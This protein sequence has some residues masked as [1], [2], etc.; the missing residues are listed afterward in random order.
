MLDGPV[1]T[2]LSGR[3]RW[4][5]PMRLSQVE[6]QYLVSRGIV[7]TVHAPNLAHDNPPIN[8]PIFN[9]VIQ[10]RKDEQVRRI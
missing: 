6:V 1:G 8:A 9:Q 5:L 4:N 7:Q 10:Q 3:L 2:G